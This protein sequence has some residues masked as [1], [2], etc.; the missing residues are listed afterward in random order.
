MAAPTRLGPRELRD[1]WVSVASVVADHAAA[2][3]RLDRDELL[4]PEAVQLADTDADADADATADAAAGADLDAVL[5]AVVAATPEQPSMAAVVDAVAAAGSVRGGPTASGITAVLGGLAEGLRNADALDA[6]RFAIGLELG[7]EALSTR[8]GARHSGG[9][10]AVVAAA[11]DGALAAVDDGADLAD[12]LLAAVDDGFAE[13]ERGP[14]TNPELVERGVVDAAAAGFLLMLDALA[15]VVTGEPLPAA[16]VEPA[17]P[18]VATTARRYSLS[19]SIEPAPGADVESVAWLGAALHEL[20]RV[21]LLE[22]GPAPWR[23]ELTTSVPGAAVETVLEV[24]RPRELRIVVLET[25]E[26]RAG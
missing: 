15:S 17:R 7:A 23:L 12:V 6:Q 22:H 18:S 11:A 3:D 20:G 8:D 10:C 24:G 13:L 25:D 2:L 26:Q 19:C 1:A 21:E 9:L 16:P 5:R 14:S 4:E